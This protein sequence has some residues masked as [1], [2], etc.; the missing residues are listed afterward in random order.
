MARRNKVHRGEAGFTLLEVMMALTVLA[1][2][3]LGVVALQAATV[4][5][6]QDAAQFQT[7]N[8][9]ARTW[10]QRLQRD[11]Q[12]WNHP[13][14][15][16][17]TKDDIGETAW[18]QNADTLS[19]KWFKPKMSDLLEPGASAAF[20]RNGNDIRLDDKVGLADR[21]VFCTNLRLRR[22]YPDLV[23]AE[24]RVYWLKRRLGNGATFIGYGFKD[25]ICSVDGIEDALGKDTENFHW[26]Y[27]VAGIP[28]ATS[29]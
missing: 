15:I 8:A 29:Q 20:D 13:S 24:V 22:L 1:I 19:N 21:T 17:P 10:V 7:A 6:T 4:G 26:A 2:G 16:F 11:A 23:Q 27:A 3:L 14:V 12:R 9:I 18:L 28:K 25:G 5:S